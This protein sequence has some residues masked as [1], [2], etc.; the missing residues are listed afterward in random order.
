MAYELARLR[1]TENS[2]VADIFVDEDKVVFK[3]KNQETIT[4]SMY[5]EDE[6]AFLATDDA[7]VTKSKLSICCDQGAFY[8]RGLDR[9]PNDR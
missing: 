5:S 4:F 7:D 3:L 8:A 9:L 6:F 1:W 2:E